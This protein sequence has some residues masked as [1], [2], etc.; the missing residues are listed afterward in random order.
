M[1]FN[2]SVQWSGYGPH[3]SAD[4]LFYYWD[5]EASGNW[6]VALTST[7]NLTNW[8]EMLRVVVFLYL[9]HLH[10]AG[11]LMIHV[12]RTQPTLSRVFT[13]HTAPSSSKTDVLSLSSHTKHITY[14]GCR[15]RLIFK[16]CF[17]YSFIHC[18]GWFTHHLL[19]VAYVYIT[20]SMLSGSEPTAK[21]LQTCRGYS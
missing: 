6:F 16:C 14:N 7:S 15:F 21:I 4:S 2:H 10:T 13:T 3:L 9:S 8:Y 17:L 12:A 5:S 19:L 11:Q 18:F 1:K 20:P